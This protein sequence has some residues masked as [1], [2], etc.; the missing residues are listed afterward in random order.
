[1]LRI[2]P[3]ENILA[4]YRR[5]WLILAF[6]IATLIFVGLIF[7]LAAVL[8]AIFIPAVRVYPYITLYC[9]LST[10]F[11]HGLFVVLFI[12]I[13]DYWLDAWIITNERIIDIEQKGLFSRE[14]SEFKLDKIQDVSFDVRGIIP[15]FFRYG[16]VQV[17]TAGSER[18][19]V[20]YTV[21]NPQEIK[22]KILKIHD[23]YMELKNFQDR[24]RG[25]SNN[26]GLDK[27]SENKED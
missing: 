26:Q 1:M 6:E 16:D 12:R 17:Q 10:T 7:I 5:H 21:P 25:F 27:E 4:V 9:W 22:N 20:F 11:F 14:V 19:F 23:E 3:N 2:N 18:N 13:A 8:L 15:T 24:S